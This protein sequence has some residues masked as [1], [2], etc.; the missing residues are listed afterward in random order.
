MVTL[1]D[2]PIFID[3]NVLI[4]ANVVSAPYHQLAIETLQN[5]NNSGVELWLSRQILREFIATL[6]RPQTFVDI[7]PP[8]VIAE[9]VQFFEQFFRITE[10]S[11]QVTARLLELL[12]SIPM[13]GRQIHDANIV[14]T[15]LT[16]GI[17]Q[18]LT[19]NVRDFHRFSALITVIPLV[20]AT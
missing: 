7:Q 6:T 17:D 11:A 15:L 2:R 16:A 20:A 9:R 19:H 4:Y 14:A 3:T 12:Q 10:D 18:L 8:D 5:L 13:G 1:G